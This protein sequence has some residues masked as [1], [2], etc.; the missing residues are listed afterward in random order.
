LEVPIYNSTAGIGCD[1]K[2]LKKLEKSLGKG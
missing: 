1:F 2:S